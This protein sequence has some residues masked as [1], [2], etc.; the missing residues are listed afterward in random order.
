MQAYTITLPKKTPWESK[1]AQQFMEQQLFAFPRSVFQIVADHVQMVWQILDLGEHEQGVVENAIRAIYP[2]AHINAAAPDILRRSDTPIYRYVLKY[3]YMLPIFVAPIQ[4]VADI[5]EPD[6]LAAITQAMSVLQ[7]GE[8]ISYTLIVVGLTENAY[9]EAEK[10][11]LRPV[12]DGGVL[13]LLFPPKVERYEPHLQQVLSEKIKQPLFQCLLMV[14]VDTPHRERMEGLLTVVDNQI[15]HFDR[16][17]FNGVRWFEE[18]FQQHITH[19]T[20][21]QTDFAS[22]F[23]GWYNEFLKGKAANAYVQKVRTATR[24]ILTP[25]EIA[26]L[27]HLPHSG[28]QATTI[29][30][31]RGAEVGLA[32]IMKGKHE[33]I[34]LGINR[35]LGREEA[36]YLPEEDRATHCLIVGKSGTGKS[37]VLHHLIHQDI[38]RGNGV[39]VVDPHGN[40]VRD[41]L[42][43][44]IPR[45]RE[46][47]VV[48]LDLANAEHPI[49]LNPLRGMQNEV[50]LGRVVS[51]LHRLYEDLQDLPQTADALEN[52][53]L[54]LQDESGATLRDVNRVFLDEGYRQKLLAR[55]KD[56]VLLEFWDHDYGAVS[57][58]LQKQISAPVIRRVRHLYRN[59]HLRRI[60]C[61]PDG[62]DM[63]ALIRQ[64]KII[65]ISLK[66]DENLIPEREQQLIGALLVARLQMTAMSGGALETPFYCYIDEV[67]HFV[68][69]TIEKVFSEARKSNLSLTVAHQYLK[70]LA[71][72]TLDAVLGNV[73]V[74]MTF[75]AGGQDDAKALASYMKPEMDAEDLLNLNKYQAAVWMRYKGEQQPAFS[76][77]PFSPMEKPRDA[78][79]RETRIR[80]LS[81]TQYTPKRREE[82]V[83]W[84]SQRYGTVQEEAEQVDFYDASQKKNNNR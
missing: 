5:R 24:L 82:V 43:S 23:V 70:Q 60:I 65:L 56:D 39:M 64:R 75:Q 49:P 6:P 36:V 4:A 16:S 30:W 25:G 72:S 61:H 67:Q 40:L 8:R 19:I 79:E 57:T 37:N 45:S 47:D 48:L 7:E 1:R 44:S 55:V 76:L 73:G 63:A 3:Q 35:Y 83:D 50:A 41:L 52:A 59:A 27:W 68:T 17:G 10:L 71:G 51:V 42:H 11:M 84:L 58:A 2:E 81:Q 28:H 54:L 78:Q 77:Q 31:T 34:C 13:N 20:D 12:Y 62:L 9:K 32:A 80:R 69:T 66:A 29:A 53:L 33:G 15:I 74:V 21:D 22:S 46:E 18:P 26:A 14:Q 38:Q